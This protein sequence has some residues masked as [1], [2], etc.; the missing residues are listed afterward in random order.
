MIHTEQ[1]S[2]IKISRTATK[3]YVYPGVV[4]TLRTLLENDHRI[5]IWTNEY[6]ENVASSRLGLLRREL[7]PNGKKRLSV[8]TATAENDKLAALPY[9]F[10]EAQNY[11]SS[12]IV[13]IDN[14]KEKLE[15]TGQIIKESDIQ[16]DIKM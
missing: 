4:D 10:R 3:E 2:R 16:K 9:L 1:E 12:S 7:P 13:I 15:K 11:H 6:F 5:V 14:T 8:V